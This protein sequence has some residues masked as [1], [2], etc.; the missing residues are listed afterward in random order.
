MCFPDKYMVYK[1][2]NNNNNL[3]K[4]TNIIIILIIFI[5]IVVLMLLLI[6][7]KNN[8]NIL[9]HKIIEMGNLS[10]EASS[11]EQ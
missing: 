3:M 10:K 1:I 5:L 8:I 4:T 11:N 7:R 6:R 2:E 9:Y